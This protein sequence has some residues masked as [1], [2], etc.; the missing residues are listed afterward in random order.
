M[1]CLN[2]KISLKD[3]EKEITE[4]STQIGE[5]NG[6]KII[7][8]SGISYEKALYFCEKAVRNIL[9]SDGIYLPGLKNILI[10]YFMVK[11]MTNLPIKKDKDGNLDID[12][13]YN[14]M[15]S[16][17]GEKFINKFI[18]RPIYSF[19]DDEIDQ[20]LKFK[21][22]IYLKTL[23][24]KNKTLENIDNLIFDLQNMIQKISSFTDEHKTLISSGMLNKMIE[25]LDKVKN[26]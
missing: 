26:K 9:N 22:E 5:I 10:F 21:K 11:N 3:L 15:Y 20:V 1:I 25:T 14:L 17:V 24:S 18:A 12:Y 6:K 2:E 13:I 7:F 23:N 4:E 16:K 19:L 8:N